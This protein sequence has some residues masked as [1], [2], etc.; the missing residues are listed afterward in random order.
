MTTPHP[1][2][3]ASRATFTIGDLAEA[4]GVTHRTLRFYEDK[5]LLNPERRGQQRLFTARDKARLALIL[6][7]KR[8]GFSLEEIRDM[9]ELHELD[10]GRGGDLSDVLERFDARIET[11]KAQRED[12]D[13][14]LRDLEAGREWLRARLD[15]RDIPRDLAQRAA[16][17]EALA[18]GWLYPDDVKGPG[19][20]SPDARGQTR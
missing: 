18:K 19:S 10:G 15:G 1:G 12:I 2:S 17:F 4:F 20:I 8:V 11:L 14:A 7:G 3:N 5:G 13:A 16:A 9:L 6:R